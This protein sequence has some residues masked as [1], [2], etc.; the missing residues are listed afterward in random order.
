MTLFAI[1]QIVAALAFVLGLVAVQFQRRRD[2]L[3]CLTTS[4]L[5]NAIHFALLGRPEAAALLG[6]TGVRY[7]VA[8]K[9]VN[10]WM[11]LVFM[12]LST[13]IFVV[14]YSD[15]LSWLAL[16]GIIFGT[17]GSFQPTEQ[18]MRVF[19]MCGTTSW[20]LHS[21]LTFTPVGILMQA[22]FLA[23]NA[24]GYWRHSRIVGASD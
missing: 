11:M 4:V 5:V 19:F 15:W 14:T 23:S 1:S 17:Y 6:L 24:I 21:A 9:T 2:V 10:R 7:L 8:I 18:Q 20:L 16:I 13:V 3:L 12:G 22:S